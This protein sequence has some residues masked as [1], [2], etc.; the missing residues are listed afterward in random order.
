M[1]LFAYVYINCPLG[2]TLCYSKTNL[3]R[4]LLSTISCMN[5]PN[6]EDF[7]KHLSMKQSIYSN[8]CA[9]FLSR[10]H[11]LNRTL[12]EAPQIQWFANECL[13]PRSKT[14]PQKHG[15]EKRTEYVIPKA[16]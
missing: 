13:L 4:I 8:I 15:E 1:P 6:D 11:H 10:V 16:S 3:K 14:L 5:Y 12:R 2:Q 7:I 9:Q